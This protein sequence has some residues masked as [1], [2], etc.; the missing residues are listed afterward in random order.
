MRRPPSPIYDGDVDPAPIGA[1]GRADHRP[2]LGRADH[3]I[4]K[5]AV[6]LESTRLFDPADLH[7][8]EAGRS[9]QP[10]DFPAGAVVIGHVKQHGWF[11]LPAAGGLEQIG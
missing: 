6:H 8:L 4:M 5:I 3:E 9:D 1:S 10:L 2:R 11:R 7:R